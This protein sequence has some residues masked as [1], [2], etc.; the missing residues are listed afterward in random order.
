MT[1]WQA[2]GI[3]ILMSAVAFVTGLGLAA[4]ATRSE[5]EDRFREVETSENRVRVRWLQLLKAEQD[6][7]ERADQQAVVRDLHGNPHQT[8]RVC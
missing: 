3:G 7:Q 8:G 6:L 2:F 5:L 4:A 1:I